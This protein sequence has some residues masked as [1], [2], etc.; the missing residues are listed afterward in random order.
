MSKKKRLL[1]DM[2]PEPIPQYLKE[3][4]AKLVDEGV[5][6]TEFVRENPDGTPCFELR[7]T[8]L[9]ALR[10]KNDQDS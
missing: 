2:R 10:R 3:W 9:R 5:P 6:P 1:R 7:T 4:A 8:V